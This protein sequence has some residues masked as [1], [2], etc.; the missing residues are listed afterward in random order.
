MDPIPLV[1]IIETERTVVIATMNLMKSK[2]H[3]LRIWIVKSRSRAASWMRLW[4]LKNGASSKDGK[5][6]NGNFGSSIAQKRGREV[7]NVKKKKVEELN[8]ISMADLIMPN[9]PR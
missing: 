7:R 2:S 1:W 9:V 8:G 3:A 6:G 5:T 4:V